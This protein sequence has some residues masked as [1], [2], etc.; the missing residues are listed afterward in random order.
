MEQVLA[1]CCSAP[2]NLTR[3]A[4]SSAKD[5]T[6]QG[7]ALLQSG[8][9]PAAAINDSGVVPSQA[10]SHPATGSQRDTSANG[11]SAADHIGPMEELP[12]QTLKD[13]L[14]LGSQL[15]GGQRKDD[16]HNPTTEGCGG[17]C[18]PNSLPVSATD[19]ACDVVVAQREQPMSECHRPARAE[20][21]PNASGEE[22]AAA[23][24]TSPGKT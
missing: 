16:S 4:V 13:Q 23:V 18:Q 21:L 17:R 7:P 2:Q 8:F 22:L 5:K 3:Q 24:S 20:Q 12:G 6:R 9:R 11:L 1:V 19:A 14:P 10:L 15:A